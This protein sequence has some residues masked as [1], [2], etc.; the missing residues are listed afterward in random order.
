MHFKLLH[1]W[2]LESC[3]VCLYGMTRQ[4]SRQVG[5]A[6]G[7]GRQVRAVSDVTTHG[8]CRGELVVAATDK[9]QNF[10]A[11]TFA[12]EINEGGSKIAAR[13]KA[14]DP[15]VLVGCHDLV[16]AILVVEIHVG[17]EMVRPGILLQNFLLLVGRRM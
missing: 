10:G 1:L 4:F 17:S 7:F 9:G 8:E 11:V 3:R 16:Q 5:E 6:F 13:V 14:N 12:E 15:K 2:C